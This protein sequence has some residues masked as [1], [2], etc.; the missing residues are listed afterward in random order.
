M[1]QEGTFC[2]LTKINILN[3]SELAKYSKPLRGHQRVYQA[4]EFLWKSMIFRG[5]SFCS[6]PQS[7]QNIETAG[8][9]EGA[10]KICTVFCGSS[11]IRSLVCATSLSQS[12]KAYEAAGVQPAP[13]VGVRSEGV[14][15]ACFAVTIWRHSRRQHREPSRLSQFPQCFPI[16]MRV[17]CSN[18]IYVCI[19]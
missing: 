13:I 3:S 6:N 15:E 19:P 14:S 2:I 11:R 17:L 5:F 12:H 9:Q 16:E 18:L 7:A 4:D 8:V 1:S 10:I